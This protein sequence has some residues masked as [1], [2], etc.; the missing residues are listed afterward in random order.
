MT[1][2]AVFVGCCALLWAAD[3]VIGVL[4]ETALADLGR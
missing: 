4:V 3:W 1:G 2:L